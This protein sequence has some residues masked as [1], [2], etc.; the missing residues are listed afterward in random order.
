MVV[1][2][3]VMIVM[4]VSERTLLPFTVT[5]IF[6][7][8]AVSGTL[9]RSS[10]D[11]LVN[12]VAAT[13]LTV[14]VFS[15]LFA[16]K[17][18][19]VIFTPYPTP[20]INGEK[21]LTLSGCIKSVTVNEFTEV[22]VVPFTDTEIGALDAPAGT[23]T[24]SLFSVA[25]TT[26]AWT[27]PNVTVFAEV[28]VLKPDPLMTI[29]APTVSCIG[30]MLEMTG[31]KVGAGSAFLQP[32]KNMNTH[33]THEQTRAMGVNFFIL[34]LNRYNGSGEQA[35]IDPLNIIPINLRCKRQTPLS[36]TRKKKNLR[37]SFI[38]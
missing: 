22:P 34:I 8:V 14:T 13:P 2:V 37:L 23:T 35:S 5:A 7:V 3:A 21:L 31:V 4:T 36:S 12:T 27:V 38:S 18:V 29:W 30:T 1:M 9:N 24:T 16:L 26:I 15:L 10:V 20:E 11:E 17:P 32:D 19:P 33:T 6:P 25:E 28:I